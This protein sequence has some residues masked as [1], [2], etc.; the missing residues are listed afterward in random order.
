MKLEFLSPGS[1]GIISGDLFPTVVRQAEV[2]AEEA[3]VAH[4]SGIPVFLLKI[5]IQPRRGD[6][7]RKVR[8]THRSMEAVFV[9]SLQVKFWGVKKLYYRSYF[10]LHLSDEKVLTEYR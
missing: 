10:S 5:K 7:P 9:F 3:G 8:K 4:M 1:N 2:N 6:A